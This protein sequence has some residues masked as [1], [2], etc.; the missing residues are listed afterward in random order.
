MR[1]DRLELRAFGP[2]RDQAIDLSKGKEGLHILYGDNEAGKSSTL[3]A[4]TAALFGIPKSTNDAFAI[5]RKDLRIGATLRAGKKQISY[6]WRRKDK[7]ALW[8][9]A[10]EAH[11]SGDALAPF[12]GSLTKEHFR[13]F[14]GMGHGDLV[15]GGRML[16]TGQTDLGTALFAAAGGLQHLTELR[17]K[18][19]EDA[20]LLYKKGGQNPS[21]NKTLKAYTAAR[22]RQKEFS[23]SSDAW[24]AVYRELEQHRQE[25]ARLEAERNEASARL[26][27]VERLIQAAPL[28]AHRAHLLGKLEP[29]KDV[30]LL[31][32]DLRD[33]YRKALSEEER[34][35]ERLGRAEE[36]ME[37]LKTDLDRLSFPE[38][39]ITCAE[40]IDALAEEAAKVAALASRCASEAEPQLRE[41]LAQLNVL[42]DQLG[43]T[44]TPESAAALEVPA[45]IQ[46]RITTL[47]QEAAALNQARGATAERVETLKAS[48]KKLEGRTTGQTDTPDLAALEAQLEAAQHDRELEGRAEE[49]TGEAAALEAEAAQAVERLPYWS[50]DVAA[51]LKLKCPNKAAITSAR[52]ELAGL[53]RQVETTRERRDQAAAEREALEARLREV[54]ATGALPSEAD[55]KGLRAERD[56][57]WQRIHAAWQQGE[58][59]MDK[60]DAGLRN[61]L[62][63]PPTPPKDLSLTEAFLQRVRDADDTADT[64]RREASRVADAAQLRARLETSERAL[65]QAAAAL[66]AAESECAAR[67]EAWLAAWDACGMESVGTPVEML[68]WFQDREAIVTTA[69]EAGEARAR[70]RTLGE[71][72]QEKLARLNAVLEEASGKP[73]SFQSLREATARLDG[74]VKGLREEAL[75]A[76]ERA[77]QRR[78]LLEDELPE[79][80]AGAEKA[81]QAWQT[82]RSDWAVAMEAIGLDPDAT[83]AA[84]VEGLT[85]RGRAAQLGRE[86]RAAHALIDQHAAA[87]AHLDERIRAAAKAALPE[88]QAEDAAGLLRLLR[89]QCAAAREASL[90]G[91][92]LAR[93]LDAAR[94]QRERAQDQ[95]AAAR[96]TLDVCCKE[97]GD[98][99]I[100]VLP[101][102]IDRADQRRGLEKDL[103]NAEEQLIAVAGG[104]TLEAFARALADQDDGE[105]ETE[106]SSCTTLLETRTAELSEL[107]TT[108]GRLEEKLG[109]MDG[110]PEAAEARAEAEEQLAAL[111][112]D[113][114]AYLRLRLGA[115]VLQRAIEAYREREQGPM[116]AHAGRHF[117]TLTRGSFAGLSTDFEGDTP[118][119][120]GRREDGSL[121][122]LEGMS[123]GTADQLYLALRLAALELYFEQHD[124]VP[125]VLD[126]LLIN[127]DDDR[128]R[129]ALEVLAEVSQRTQVILFTHHRHVLDLAKESVPKKLLYAQEFPL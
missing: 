7:N 124:P 86:A 9:A 97:A 88:A 99:A 18:L 55:L 100:D 21:I 38:A 2:F 70:S 95:V 51:F 17:G 36:E 33:R 22:K 15:E 125:L 48:A 39:L 98:V 53:E 80:E 69:R 26:R 127:F 3:R 107:D 45:D 96:A 49:T 85:L 81:A 31:A 101:E 118:L 27:R 10:D 78:A 16:T 67:R 12:L 116:L 112:E 19:N 56:G 66:T 90:K 59:P 106:R 58:A 93:N 40:E 113:V 73:A 110:S 61:S 92:V 121:V 42:G 50:G 35:A 62:V 83:P 34:A 111:E 37:R 123:E 23:L 119:L 128:A 108:I 41:C 47:S 122:R 5:P 82:W 126:D 11:L 84:G 30:P 64:L 65:E 13:H 89:E 103:G 20:G 44:L 117:T 79:A 60:P 43:T 1:I 77:E 114:A 32:A 8:D 76:T 74:L 24:E 87:T 91:E 63:T 72:V 71:T 129:A 115:S 120:V 52:D 75:L 6:T 25:R 102:V 105:R 4:L 94:E 104:E 57:L 54:S 14:F 28:A 68:E 46:D 29:L 109:V